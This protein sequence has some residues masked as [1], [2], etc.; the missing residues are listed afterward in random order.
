[1]K[2]NFRFIASHN[3]VPEATAGP[4]RVVAVLAFHA[5]RSMTRARASRDM[6]VPSGTPT[7][8]A[9][10]WYDKLLISRSTIVLRNGGDGART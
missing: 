1:M 8:W 6:T 3:A 4:G 7:T 10:S 5:A 2:H 9:I